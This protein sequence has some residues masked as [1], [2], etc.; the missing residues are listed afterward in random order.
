M[1]DL[2]SAAFLAWL[3]DYETV[4]RTPGTDELGTLFAPDATY[5][6][7]P[8]DAPH[9]GL[10]AIAAMWEDARDGSG[11]HFT[12]TRSVVAVTGD[13]GV[14]R[15]TVRYGDPVVQ[16]YVDLWVVRFDSAGR[17]VH[18]EEWPYWPG[19]AHHA[20][21]RTEPVVVSAASLEAA[22]WAEW[23]R[24]QDLSSGVY[25]LPVG[26]VDGQKPHREDEVYVVTRGAATLDIE[27]V[28]HPVS[29]R[30]LAFVPKRA[31]HRFVDVTADFET[32]V[33]FAPPEMET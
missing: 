19:R 33:V 11:E 6:Q 23:V 4:W 13:T 18:F 5:L 22:P 12:M 30:S 16:E 25:R 9:E 27:G 7:S 28:R 21:A 29:A 8:V 1:A 26:A 17:A 3:D 2:D 14:A 24:S 32:V 20:D 15:V 10:A 31:E